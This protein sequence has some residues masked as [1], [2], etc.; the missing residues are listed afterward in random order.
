[1]EIVLSKIALS[2]IEHWKRTNN[3]AILIKQTGLFMQLLITNCIFTLLKGIKTKPILRYQL[4]KTA[5]FS[6]RISVKDRSLRP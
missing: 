2:H 5:G 1:M 3:A 6:M 4:A